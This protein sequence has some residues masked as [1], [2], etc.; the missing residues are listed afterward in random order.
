MKRL[1]F[2]V[3]VFALLINC[4]IA[5]AGSTSDFQYTIRG[6]G[7]IR[8]DEYIGIDSSVTIPA[9]IE[10]YP[11][12]QIGDSAFE[13]NTNLSSVT[14]E[15]ESITIGQYAFYGCSDLSEVFFTDKVQNITIEDSAFYGCNSLLD[16]SIPD[17]VQVLE[18]DEDAFEYLDSLQTVTIGSKDTSIGKYGFYYCNG[19]TD[20]IFTENVE[21]I[22]I[23]ES[24]FAGCDSLTEL[25]IPNNVKTLM[26]D[27]DAFE[28][29]D[30]LQDVTINSTETT[31][32]KYA[33][34]H[35]QNLESVVFN[36]NV[37]NLTIEDSAFSG[38]ETLTELAIVANAEKVSIGEDVFEYNSA[39]Q[40]VNIGG[41]EI[42][43][44]NYAF[45]YCKALNKVTFTTQGAVLKLAENAFSS[46]GNPNG[47]VYPS[48]VSFDIAQPNGDSSVTP[49]AVEGAS[50]P[51][52]SAIDDALAMA[53]EA[54]E[55]A[56]AEAEA[57]VATAIAE[58]EQAAGISLTASSD[59]AIDH[60]QL[61]MK[62]Y[63]G[64]RLDEIGYTSLGGD[65]FDR[66]SPALLE[67]CFIT[68][69]GSYI[70]IHDNEVLR[71]YVVA[72]QNIPAG[73]SFYYVLQ[74]DSNGE[75][76]SNLIDYQSISQIDLV[77]KKAS[78]FTMLGQ[79]DAVYQATPVNQPT[80]RYTWFINNY[81]GKNLASIGYTS[82]GGDRFDKYGG[83]LIELIPMAV[84]GSFV[85]IHDSELLQQYVVIGQSAAP[86]TEFHIEFQ[87]DSSGKE[88]SNLTEY[89]TIET[90]YLLVRKVGDS[91]KHVLSDKSFTIINLADDKYTWYIRDYTGLNLAAVGYTSL[92]G[93][94][95]DSY[96]GGHIEFIIDAE[97]NEWIDIEDKELMQ[98]FIIVEQ[99]I[100]PNTQF[101][102]AY[103]TD[104]S[105][106]VYSNLVDYQT[107]EKIRIRV[108]RIN[109]LTSQDFDERTLM[110][111]KPAD[112]K[113]TWYIRDYTGMNLTAFG[114]NSWGGYRMDEYS[115]TALRLHFI[116]DDGSVVDIENEL[117]M[118]QYV[119]TSQ[120]PEPNTQLKLVYTKDSNGKEY[121]NLV[122]SKSI[123]D[124]YLYLT[125][126]TD[127]PTST[128]QRPSTATEVS[129][130]TNTPSV[131]PSME[132]TAVPT[133]TPA[134]LPTDTPE[135]T[136]TIDIMATSQAVAYQQLFDR[137]AELVELGK[138]DSALLLLDTIPDYEGTDELKTECKYQQAVTLEEDGEYI[139][140]MLAF[141]ELGNYKDS[142]E[143]FLKITL[144]LKEL[145]AGTASNE[146]TTETPEPT[147]TPTQVPQVTMADPDE[148][149]S[150]KEFG[151]TLKSNGYIYY[152][153]I[154]HNNRSDV[155]VRLPSYRITARD[156]D[157]QLLGT[158]RQVLNEIYPG[159][160]TYF[161]G[162]AFSVTGKPATVEIEPI[163]PDSYNLKTPAN[164]DHETY[165]PLE[166]KSIS[167]KSDFLGER[168]L[169]EVYN[170]NAYDLSMVQVCILFRDSSASLIG[171]ECTYVDDVKANKSVPFE[172]LGAGISA[173]SVEGYAQPW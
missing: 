160:D 77:V 27:E 149:F 17:T 51:N 167:K 155:A 153:V 55:N 140:A 147:A 130:P 123:E 98:Q 4:C 36:E 7:T 31:I 101:K 138:C 134:P 168:Y 9:K 71:Q 41:K 14:F 24:S 143:R 114:Y 76:Y 171:G 166:V 88:Y 87:K 46:I 47:I 1:I 91:D 61:I 150:V 142:S 81:V 86:N 80:D 162:M 122:S 38:C 34:Y 69:D 158:D 52:E 50:N 40:T 139:D 48:D 119:V 117:Q 5:I 3:I 43:I 63:V 121:S 56:V 10:E 108:K 72:A 20:L 102:I 59:N 112:D 37:I 74:K 73:T 106:K 57:A 146:S 129:Q 151:W 70:D 96:G 28:Y 131:T 145:L 32:K 109:N 110:P 12:T 97:N 78:L 132:P 33:F 163:T 13:Y 111:I 18:I 2:I 141:N 67:V 100:I 120:N 156:K 75:E 99:D 115:H 83:G 93:D 44:G 137:A 124:I 154:L 64:K 125:K 172:T 82:L 30:G 26:I 127:D 170:P 16:F 164:M 173:V 49:S 92:G 85:D 161:A 148:V 60:H 15:S 45:Y 54:L 62:N 113:Y 103:Q 165:I 107:I 152:A 84:D 159:Q 42:T 29:N 58:A 53:E 116:T 89:Q 90:V 39:L 133:E 65:R 144:N 169:G 35:C 105:G 157:G 94:R 11:V 23:G 8:I 21:N 19:L 68:E 135:P 22:T 25:L 104:S 136:A 118:A 66:Y 6:N 126:R 128:F 79:T 95:L